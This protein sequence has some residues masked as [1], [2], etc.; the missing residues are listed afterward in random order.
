MPMI[1]SVIWHTHTLCTERL[2]AYYDKCFSLM[3]PVVQRVIQKC[4]LRLENTMLDIEVMK[5]KV[6]PLI[7]H[8][9]LEQCKVSY[10]QLIISEIHFIFCLFIISVLYFILYSL[11]LLIK[12]QLYI[13]NYRSALPKCRHIVLGLLVNLSRSVTI[14][15][16][17]LL[18]WH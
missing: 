15:A 16:K 4:P 7:V 9:P 18:W 8:G 17:S 1:K 12:T 10:C 6:T 5:P 11:K 3:F 14:V 2:K 13:I